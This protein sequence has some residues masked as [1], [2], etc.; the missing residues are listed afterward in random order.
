MARQHG[1]PA[2]ALR[3][4]LSERLAPIR[5]AGLVVLLLGL[6][7][8]H[9]GGGWE[10]IP[11]A[12]VLAAVVVV[13]LLSRQE[14]RAD[15]RRYGR[16]YAG[17]AAVG[18]ALG[19]L[20]G[21]WRVFHDVRLGLENADHVVVGPRGV[22]SVE[23]KNYSGRILATPGG[24]FTH[25]QRNDAAVRQAWRQA[26]KLREL[27][28]V[29]VTPLLVFAGGEPEGE[30]VGDLLVLSGAELVPYLLSLTE[31]RLEY[32]QARE[33]FALLDERTA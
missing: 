13:A 8:A 15:L 12:V 2:K 31:R 20:P 30:R 18:A 3:D 24:L 19:A 32:A 28:G 33:V 1:T 11:G 27:L 4:R 17:E 25:G 9:R 29:E 14:V 21:G 23:V 16:G 6:G 22:F 26:R 5:A 10:V 7:A